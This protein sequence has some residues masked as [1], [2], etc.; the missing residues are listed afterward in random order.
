MASKSECQDISQ[1]IRHEEC[2]GPHVNA[3]IG[4]TPYKGRPVTGRRSGTFKTD[5]TEYESLQYCF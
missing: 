5:I 3:R 2:R 1:D 4:F